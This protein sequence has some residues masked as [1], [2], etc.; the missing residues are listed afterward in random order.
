[1]NTH[2]ALRKAGIGQVPSFDALALK[3]QLR[4]K[5]RSFAIPISWRLFDPKT[6]FAC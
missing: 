1:M 3:V 4:F 6:D 2:I 5:K